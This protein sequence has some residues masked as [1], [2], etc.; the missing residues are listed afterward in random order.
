MK[1][2]LAL[3]ALAAFTTLAPAKS[4][5][6]TVLTEISHS[7]HAVTEKA[8]ATPQIE[9][10]FSPDG[11]SEALVLKVIN[12]SQQSI[13][14][15]GYSFKRPVLAIVVGCKTLHVELISADATSIILNPD[16][17]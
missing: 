16:D 8:P 14:L 7:V 1:R 13:R 15:A 12:T 5:F 3:T 2:I 11:G 17:K 4:T 10:A 6:E 9:N